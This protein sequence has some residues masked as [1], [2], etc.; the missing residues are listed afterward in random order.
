MNEDLDHRDDTSALKLGPAM[1]MTPYLK[2]PEYRSSPPALVRE[3][4]RV[5]RS[6]FQDENGQVY[7]QFLLPKL[8]DVDTPS[9]PFSLRLTQ[10]LSHPKFDTNDV[11]EF[12][13]QPRTP[14]SHVVTPSPHGHKIML[15]HRRIM[16]RSTSYSEKNVDDSNSNTGITRQ[17]NMKRRHSSTAL[18][19]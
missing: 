7:P 16:S 1:F 9:I 10:R 8:D 14:A 19:A 3:K 15:Q 13:L 17:T 18:S 5:R 12:C 2:M 6:I 11:E 4:K